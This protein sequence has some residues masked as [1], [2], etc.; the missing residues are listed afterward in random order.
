MTKTSLTIKLTNEGNFHVPFHIA[1]IDSQRNNK[2]KKNLK[3]NK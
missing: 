1:I 2:P 3:L